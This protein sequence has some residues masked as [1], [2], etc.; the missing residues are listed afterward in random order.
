MMDNKAIIVPLISG[1][2][3]AGGGS[4]GTGALMDYRIDQA[5]EK[6]VLSTDNEKKLLILEDDYE[7]ATQAIKENNELLR[8]NEKIGSDIILLFERMR[9]PTD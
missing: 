8:K 9:S 7:E 6:C 4:L 3:G 1:I 5:S 2:L